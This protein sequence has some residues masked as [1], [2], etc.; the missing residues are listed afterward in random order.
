MLGSTTEIH[1]DQIVGV[2]LDDL[3]HSLNKSQEEVLTH[4]DAILEDEPGTS[5]SDVCLQ[6]AGAKGI[7]YKLIGFE[8]STDEM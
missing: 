4:L 3:G 1:A 7:G 5:F 8:V 2:D 6:S